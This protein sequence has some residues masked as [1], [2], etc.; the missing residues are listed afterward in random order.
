[1]SRGAQIEEVVLLMFRL[2]L[3][4]IFLVSGTRKISHYRDFIRGSIEFKVLPDGVA[5]LGGLI[6]PWAELAVAIALLVG[7][8]LPATAAVTAALIGFFLSSVVINLRRGRDIPCNCYGIAAPDLIG[9]GTIGRNLILFFLAVTVAG[10]SLSSPLN[11][12]LAFWSND[13]RL[14]G[15]TADALLVLL[16]VVWVVLGIYLTEWGLEVSQRTKEFVARQRASSGYDRTRTQRNPG[17]N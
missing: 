17:L 6:L 12:S 9:W 11:V 5:R 13:L 14:V 8:A 10:I 3:G 4:L 1:M 7:I 15:N 16:L 2:S